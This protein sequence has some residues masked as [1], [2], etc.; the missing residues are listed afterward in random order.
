MRI[1]IVEDNESNMKF[2][3]NLLEM[4]GYEI[5][6]AYNAETAVVIAKEKTPDLILMDIQLPG[7]NGIT[8]AQM[9]KDDDRTKKIPII[10]ITSFAMKGDEERMIETGFDAYLAKPFNYRHLLRF[11]ESFRNQRELI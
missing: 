5:F 10:A 11:I 9:L 3:S 8:C 1:L 7:M 2:V 4:T 6:Q